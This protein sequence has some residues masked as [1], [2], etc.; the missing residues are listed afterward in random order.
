MES[1]FLSICKRMNDV[2]AG[3]FSGIHDIVL[4]QQRTGQ[5]S[6]VVYQDPEEK[7][8]Y[9]EKQLHSVFGNDMFERFCP[10]HKE[11]ATSHICLQIKSNFKSMGCASQQ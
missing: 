11:H 2:V 7:Y 10:V 1:V 9:H 6:W 5:L 4:L 3:S 8:I